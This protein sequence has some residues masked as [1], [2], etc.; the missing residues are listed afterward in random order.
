MLKIDH[1]EPDELRVLLQRAR[2]DGAQAYHVQQCATCRA[3]LGK[4]LLTAGLFR[5]PEP[6]ASTDTRHTLHLT[7]KQLH[8]LHAQTF[9][10]TELG[11]GGMT[12]FIAALRHVAGCDDCFSRFLELHEALSPSEAM[13]DG[14]VASFRAGRSFRRAGVLSILRDLAG[15]DLWFTGAPTTSSPEPDSQMSSHEFRSRVFR[16]PPRAVLQRIARL[17]EESEAQMSMREADV[18]WPGRSDELSSAMSGLTYELKAQLELLES[19]KTEVAHRRSDPSTAS[20]HRDFG[21]LVEQLAAAAAS[22][23][24]QLEQVLQLASDELQRRERLKELEHQFQ[25]REDQSPP[26]A[27]VFDDVALEVTGHWRAGQCLLMLEARD[28]QTQSPISGIQI[29]VVEGVPGS[30][31]TQRATSD[32]TGRAELLVGRTS[33]A[34]ELE[35]PWNAK[36]WRLQLNLVERPP[37]LSDTDA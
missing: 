28:P 10:R 24:Q 35:V 29:S 16:S 18:P 7:A 11:H 13:V 21:K 37:T 19:L 33:A 32:D 27:F 1:L 2:L 3:N 22:H 15:L 17:P 36:P 9:E 20:R 14:A 5:S 4:V 30:A 31:A 23:R 34:L 6:S 25:I 26:S 12:R 8:E